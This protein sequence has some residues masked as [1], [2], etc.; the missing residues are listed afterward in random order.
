LSV[1]NLLLLALLVGNA[2]GS[3]A[4]ALAGRLA[5]AA[6]TVLGAFAKVLGL[7]SIDSAHGSISSNRKE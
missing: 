2:A 6:A 3:L 4:G 5:F 1:Q 7:K